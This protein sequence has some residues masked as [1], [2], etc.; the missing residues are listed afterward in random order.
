[1]ILRPLVNE[2]SMLLIKSDFYTFEVTKDATKNQI[3]RIVK[4]K[5][6]VDVEEVR[7]IILKGKVKSQRTRRGSFTKSDTKKALVKVKKGQKIAIFEQA[8]ADKEDKVVIRTAEGEPVTVERK[9]KK[10]LL[11]GTKVKI[12][13]EKGTK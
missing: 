1:M 10:S 4:K 13:K 6:N 11:S 8:E 9:E 2:K 7:T 5:F 3:A 12:E